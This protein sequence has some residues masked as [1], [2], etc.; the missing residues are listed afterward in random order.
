M[1][2]YLPVESAV[3]RHMDPEWVWDHH[4]QLLAL[5]IDETRGVQW[6]V[7]QGSG[8]FKKRKHPER[9]PRPGVEKPQDSEVHGGGSSALPMDEMAVWLGWAEQSKPSQPRDARGRFV[10]AG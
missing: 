8:R 4:A 9:L 3:A 6:S 2:A 10:K 5:L 7:E 1:A